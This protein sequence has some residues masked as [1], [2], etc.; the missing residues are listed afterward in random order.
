MRKLI[1]QFDMPDGSG[2]QQRTD[3][4]EESWG[5]VR[6]QISQLFVTV[7]AHRSTQ[8]VNPGPPNTNPPGPSIHARVTSSKNGPRRRSD[9]SL[10]KREY[11]GRKELSQNRKKLKRDTSGHF[12][13]KNRAANTS[14]SALLRAMQQCSN[15]LQPHLEQLPYLPTLHD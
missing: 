13:G 10:R 8:S 7:T 5:L 2:G 14:C 11:Q 6:E 12:Q 15:Q 4:P 9:S 3:I 1:F